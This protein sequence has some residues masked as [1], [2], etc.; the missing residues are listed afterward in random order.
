MSCRLSKADCLYHN[1][2]C[3]Y[4]K[5]HR[6]TKK[7]HYCRKRVN[8]LDTVDGMNYTSVF[9]PKRFNR[10]VRP[11]IV[12]Q[13]FQQQQN[14]NGRVQRPTIIIQQ[15]FQQRPSVV[16]QQF[17]QGN[18]PSVMIQQFPSFGSP[19]FMQNQRKQPD[20]FPLP[21]TKLQQKGLTLPKKQQKKDQQQGTVPTKQ[22]KKDQ[23]QGTV[24]TKQQKKDQ[25][26][27]TLPKKQQK[28]GITPVKKQ[29]SIVKQ[30]S[31]SA[32]NQVNPVKQVKQVNPV[33]QDTGTAALPKYT[34]TPIL[35]LKPEFEI[36]QKLL[37]LCSVLNINIDEKYKVF[38]KAIVMAMWRVYL[39]FLPIQDQKKITFDDHDT[40][41]TQVIA[42][43]R[44][45][46]RKNTPIFAYT[47]FSIKEI[48]EFLKL[49]NDKADFALWNPYLPRPMVA[50]P[51]SLDAFYQL[52]KNDVLR[53]SELPS[54]DPL[55]ATA[56]EVRGDTLVWVLKKDL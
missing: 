12:V 9:G 52:L 4:V 46:A 31:V 39:K 37:P 1:D 27:G 49:I 15:Q 53:V 24:P 32:S 50:D 36:V 20:Y 10:A 22:Q 29:Q 55:I 8:P 35:P 14:E 28:K 51:E 44:T 43:G 33:K 45:P 11:S 3:M 17:K 13:Q 18:S 34:I 7:F 2:E 42:V 38:P 21:P 25:Q 6:L 56:G 54:Q 19:V 30:L 23:Q 40:D 16:L 47:G 26:Q 5:S 48:K 41:F